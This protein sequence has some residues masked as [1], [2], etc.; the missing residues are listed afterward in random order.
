MRKKIII[1]LILT[2]LPLMMPGVSFAFTP[3]GLLEI[4][5]INVGWGTSVLV[6]GPNG[7][8]MLMDGGRD[9]MG[10]NKVIPYLESIGIMPT[11]SLTYI[12]SSHLHSDHIAGLTEVMNGGYNVSNSVYYNGSSNSNSYVTAFRNAA[13]NHSPGPIQSLAPG[14][15]IQL[16][17]GATATCVCANGTVLGHGLV[18]GV[19]DENDK[20]IG[21][22]IQYGHFEY[23]FA[24][25][26]GGGDAD[27]ACTGRQSSYA[28]VETPLAQAIMPGGE[29]PLLTSFGVEVLH[30]NHHG[31]AKAPLIPIT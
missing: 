3:S 1:Y 21:L 26:L 24:G 4:H 9:N 7:T 23:L 13:I 27:N 11:D 29:H 31:E 30:V 15:V 2:A 17:G 10:T 8:R 6:I 16:G 5:Y 25:D 19:S 12:L 22:L 18:S 20:S 28:N 14:A